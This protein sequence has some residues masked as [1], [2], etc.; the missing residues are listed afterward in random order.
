VNVRIYNASP[1]PLRYA[2]D[3]ASGL[4][5]CANIGCER[6]ISPGSR[7]KVDTGIHLAI[8][9]GYEGQV[10]GR[11]GLAVSWGVIAAMGTID[12]DYRGPVAV[13][14]INTGRDEFIV[15]P[16]DRIAQLVIAPVTRITPVLVD[17]VADLGETVRG[18][19]GFGSTGVR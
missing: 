10:R 5:L 11:S 8:P 2:T 18:A 12:Q 13:I 14:L 6:T 16:G 17:S 3:G 7:W 9:D 4:D 19:G 1:Y 15:R